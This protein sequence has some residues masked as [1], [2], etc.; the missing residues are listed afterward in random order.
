VALLF[1][2]FGAALNT[3]NDLVYRRSAFG[4]DFSAIL[5]FYFFAAI[6]SL[7]FAAIG[8]MFNTG[9]LVGGANEILFGAG[10]GAISFCGYLLFLMSLAGGSTSVG[11][12]I[13][14]LNMV[15]AIVLAAFVL[16]ERI[17][18]ERGT[19]ILLCVVSIFLLAG[20]DKTSEGASV[21]QILL[22]IGACVFGGAATF[23]NKVAMNEGYSPFHL[24][25]WRYVVVLLL[26]AVCLSVL[27]I[28]S[29][30]RDHAKYATLSGFFMSASV[31]FI[32]KAL[33]SGDLSMVMPITQL[34]FVFVTIIS[35]VFYRERISIRKVVGSCLAIVAVILII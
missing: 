14:R 6:S 28:W 24:L 21:K 2:I 25:F 12:T 26:S 22:S 32:L 18:L 15:P 3:S 9:S 34:S 27:R 8:A 11:V 33:S 13:F 20:S 31:F 4:L 29:P 17:G 7:F 30:R 1:A 35:W 16:D 10:L 19:G 5:T 23:L